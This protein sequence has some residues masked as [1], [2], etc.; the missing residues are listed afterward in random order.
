MGLL[1]IR[2]ACPGLG[3][4]CSTCSS[5][6]YH[7]F[8]GCLAQ[9]IP[10]LQLYLPHCTKRA[11]LVST[12][13]SVSVVMET[14]QIFLG[15]CLCIKLTLNWSCV[16]SYLPSGWDE[17]V[18]FFSPQPCFKV[19]M[20]DIC[21]VLLFSGQF[22]T[23]LAFWPSLGTTQLWHSGAPSVVQNMCKYVCVCGGGR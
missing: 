21:D 7:V 22:M 11:R 3:S 16:T 19:A 14:G 8:Q 13:T 17:S 18:V 10:T 6:V 9:V 4:K 20:Q 2:A 1:I 5:P 12:N 23:S 15:T